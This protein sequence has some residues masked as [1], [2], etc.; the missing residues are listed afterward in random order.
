MFVVRCNDIFMTRGNKPDELH[1]SYY[2]FMARSHSSAKVF[3]GAHFMC[4]CRQEA[5]VDESMAG[6]IELCIMHDSETRR[7][8]RSCLHR[9]LQALNALNIQSA[10]CELCFSSTFVKLEYRQ[11]DFLWYLHNH[12]FPSLHLFSA[13]LQFSYSAFVAPSRKR[14]SKNHLL[15]WGWSLNCVIVSLWT[16]FTAMWVYG[17]NLWA[18]FS[19]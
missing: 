4:S 16:R 7:V 13:C 11:N 5:S 15:A 1:Y 9:K 8:T 6:K 12:N 10:A 2:M 18:N 19:L 3:C 14:K 17:R